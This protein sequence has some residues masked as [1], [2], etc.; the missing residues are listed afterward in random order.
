MVELAK[1]YQQTGDSD[2]AQAAMQMAIDLG[3][4]YGTASPG[5][6]VL[7]QMVGLSI[8]IRAL[9]AMDPN[10][11]YGSSGQ[12]VQDKLSQI[13]QQ[14]D[15]LRQQSEQVNAL[16]PAMSEQDWTIYNDRWLTLGEQNAYQ[17]VI[18]RYGRN[19]PTANP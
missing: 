2:S 9:N 11:A 16:L 6:P 12:T 19:S 15:N 13:K 4:R 10:A 1:S 17:W 5:E 3:Q 7:S 14:H 8:E 18:N